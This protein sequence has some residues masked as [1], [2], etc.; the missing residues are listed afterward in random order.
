MQ[1]RS[2]DGSRGTG[3]A[4]YQQVVDR[5]LA[6]IESGAIAVGESLPPEPELAAHYSVSRHTMREA[7]RILGDLGVIERRPGVGTTVRAARPRPAYLQVVRSADELLQY[8]PS[9]LRVEASGFVRTDATL[10]RLLQC[11]RGES[12]F[13]VAAVRRLR[14]TRTPIGWLDLYLQPLFAG[15]LPDIGR[16]DEPVYQ[17]LERQFGQQTASVS[18]DLGV[19]QLSPSAAAALGAEVG[20]P[21]FRLVRRYVG[22]DDQ[23]LQI[24]VTE[25]LPDQFQ[26]RLQLHRGLDPHHRWAMQP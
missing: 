3:G 12:W 9:R 8:P 15:V 1:T 13:H 6:G 7:L 16:R 2:N 18:M 5:L 19:S 24:S 25:H 26:Y 20:T 17:M 10:A 14:G 11:R 4:L 21:S 23:V 22:S